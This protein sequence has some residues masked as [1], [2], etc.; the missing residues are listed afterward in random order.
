[1]KTNEN[2]DYLII[3][4]KRSV[5]IGIKVLMGLTI[6]YMFFGVFPFD[7]IIEY[8]P[9]K[10]NYNVVSLIFRELIVKSILFCLIGLLLLFLKKSSKKI[11][12]YFLVL[13]LLAQG[14]TVIETVISE[15]TGKM[16][17]YPLTKWVDL[18]PVWAIFSLL[19][20]LPYF[21]GVNFSKELPEKYLKF[22]KDFFEGNIKIN[23]IKYHILFFVIFLIL[24][25]FFYSS[26]HPFPWK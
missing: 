13:I 5:D 16:H 11:F 18:S 22:T 23:I 19:I 9:I 12:T 4:E 7:V 21:I 1:M 24:I 8:M 25:N 10:D 14:H 3:N 26:H 20:F 15:I 2:L 6:I 17:L